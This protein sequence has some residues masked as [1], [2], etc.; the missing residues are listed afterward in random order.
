MSLDLEDVKEVT[1]EKRSCHRLISSRFPTV[2]IFDDIA[3]EEDLEA[4]YE[5]EGWTNDRIKAQLGK[6][7]ALPREQ[8]VVGRPGASQIMA[9]FC[10]PNPQGGRF[11]ASDLRAWYAAFD[12]ETA[13]AETIYHNGVRLQEAG[14][15]QARLQFRELRAKLTCQV[16]D[17]TEVGNKYEDLYQ[18]D[19]HQHSQKFGEEVRKSGGDGI[20]YKSVRY[21]AGQCI[22]L[23]KPTL[24]ESVVQGDHFEIEWSEGREPEIYRLSE[25]RRKAYK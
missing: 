6:L 19:S 18:H 17:I 11:N 14:M 8:W 9:S 1:L 7:Y 22:V 4:L 2:K 25:S 24:L 13:L 5:L 12:L 3:P 23:Y 20:V 16:Y 10:H 21:E 15:S